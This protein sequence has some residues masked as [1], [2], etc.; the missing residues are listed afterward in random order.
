MVTTSAAAG[1]GGGGGGGGR[2]E[3]GNHCQYFLTSLGLA[4]GLGNVWRFPAVCYENGGSTF[5][6]PYFIML[7]LVGL[8]L[9]FMEMV[10]GQYAGLSATKVFGRLA[11][12]LK[13]LGYGMLTIPTIINFYYTVIM[14]WS[15]FYMFA[16]FAT[17]LPWA[18]C[19]KDYNSVNCY[20]DTDAG[21]CA[22]NATYWNN[23]CTGLEEFCA[24]NGL[25][26]R[27]DN[28]THCFS[29]DTGDPTGLADVT[30]R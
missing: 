22:A 15:L 14:A 21:R 5:L 16:G 10:L 1:Q 7:F 30:F 27:P 4:V 3:W 12:G 18:T 2:G 20:S 8:P 24:A 6:I 26:Y 29:P 23:T 9:F 17:D 19:G 28:D 13:G 25:V 11:P